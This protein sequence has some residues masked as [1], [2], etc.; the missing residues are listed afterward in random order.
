VQ[1]YKIK[2]PKLGETV[3]DVLVVE[4]LVA[5]GDRINAGAELVLVETDK[6]STE[7]PTPV[8]GVVEELLVDE[9]EEIVAGHPLC[10]VRTE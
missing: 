10:W 5:V 7:V 8:G 3:E 6:T 1:R 9:G 4:W 2:L